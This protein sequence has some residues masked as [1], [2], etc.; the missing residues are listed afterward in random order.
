MPASGRASEPWPVP[1]N[2]R[3]HRSPG[4]ANVRAMIRALV[5]GLR[6]G[7]DVPGVADQRQ[8]TGVANGRAAVSV[9]TRVIFLRMEMPVFLD[10]HRGC[11]ASRVDGRSSMP[12]KI[13]SL[14][15]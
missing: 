2:D 15:Q 1:A 11:S 6:L 14:E 12:G 3:R 8:R 7:S 5:A 9:V 10:G 4:P 13:R